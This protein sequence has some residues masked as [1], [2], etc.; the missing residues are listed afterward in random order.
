MNNNCLQLWKQGL[1]ACFR[2]RW[3]LVSNCGHEGMGEIQRTLDV[4]LEFSLSLQILLLEIPTSCQPLQE[5][6][7]YFIP[8]KD[9][10]ASAIN[11]LQ[12][13]GYLGSPYEHW[14]M[15]YQEMYIHILGMRLLLTV[16]NQLKVSIS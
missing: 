2:V 7:F 13:C 15:G 9:I 12:S 6:K 3:K 16:I 5:Q 10:S 11:E 4:W 8:A 14:Y 1:H